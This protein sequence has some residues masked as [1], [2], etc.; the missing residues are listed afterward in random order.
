MTTW[1]EYLESGLPAPEWPYPV[2]YGNEIEV[3][4][5][6]LRSSSSHPAKAS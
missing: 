6:V 5:D 4:T 3:E 1:H 2:R